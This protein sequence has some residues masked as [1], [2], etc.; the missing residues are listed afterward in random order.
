MSKVLRIDPALC[1]GC[2]FCEVACSFRHTGR[3]SYEGSLIGVLRDDRMCEYVPLTCQNCPDA[4]C[5]EV[6]PTSAIGR[7][8]VE[9]RVAIDA[10]L[11]SGCELCAEVCPFSISGAL[12]IPKVDGVATVCDYCGGDPACVKFCAAG[13]L[14]YTSLDEWE[15]QPD[16]DLK[17]LAVTLLTEVKSREPG[18]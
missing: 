11:C 8:G 6:C 10:R 13:A 12:R 3:A 1:S 17:A 9:G 14:K 7:S 16:V 4:P 2:R 15:P 18:R 5:I